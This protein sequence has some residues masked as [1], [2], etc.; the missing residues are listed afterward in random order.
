MRAYIFA[1]GSLRETASAED[2]RAASEIA[3]CDLD[4]VIGPDF[5]IT[6]DQAG[7]TTPPLRED[8]KR[9]PRT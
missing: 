5:V 7:R 9:T 3:T 1:G 8:V 6:H 4:L 2:V